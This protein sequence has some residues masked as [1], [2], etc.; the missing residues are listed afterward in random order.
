MEI[1]KG[2]EIPEA[3]RGRRCKY[4]FRQMEVGD[5]FLIEDE[6]QYKKVRSAASTWGKKNGVVFTT[7]VS[8]E[9]LRVW[10]A[11]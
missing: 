2:V 5:S 11:E 9:G 1:E 7:Q 4:P 3:T 10:R 6:E 8:E